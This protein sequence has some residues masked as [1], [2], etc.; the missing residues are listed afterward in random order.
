[1]IGS[2]DKKVTGIGSTNIV[3]L[4]KDKF[5]SIFLTAQVINDLTKEINFVKI[6]AT[7]NETNTFISEYYSDTSAGLVKTGIGSF[8]SNLNGSLFEINFFNES[9]ES[10]IIRSSVVGIATTAN[11]TGTYRFLSSDQSPGTE[12][13]L[14]YQS[15][16]TTTS[17]G[18]STSILSLINQI[19]TLLDQLLKWQLVQLN[20]YI[21]SWWSLIIMTFLFNNLHSFQRQ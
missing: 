5:K 16:F 7:H 4:D 3:S 11:G 20:L 10:S 18:L 21:R 9:S 19:S 17:S 14:I 6:Y 8:D 12:K 1:M 2:V 15:G 13:S